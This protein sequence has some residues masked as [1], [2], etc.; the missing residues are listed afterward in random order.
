MLGI[1]RA[2]QIAQD[3]NPHDFKFVSKGTK[4]K[5]RKGGYVVEMKNSVVSSS[6]FE[7][8]KMNIRSLDSLQF[9]WCYYVLLIELDSHEVIL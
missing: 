9:R 5:N 1:T 3:G 2:I 8:R 7:L 6:N 4:S